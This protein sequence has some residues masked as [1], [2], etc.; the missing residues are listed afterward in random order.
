M[1]YVKPYETMYIDI[2]HITIALEKNKRDN[3]LCINDL[4]YKDSHPYHDYNAF[5]QIKLTRLFFSQA[6]VICAIL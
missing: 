2:A 1:L 6:I 3:S 5:T 4:L